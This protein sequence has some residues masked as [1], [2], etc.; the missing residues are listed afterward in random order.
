MPHWELSVQ[1]G[2]RID[3]GLIILP[4]VESRSKFKDNP[5]YDM[6]KLW[7]GNIPDLQA[8]VFRKKGDKAIHPWKIELAHYTFGV[9]MWTGFGKRKMAINF[10]RSLVE[11]FVKDYL[12]ENRVSF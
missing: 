8:N 10:A 3:N 11:S 2:V 12:E 5:K 7:T 9:R 6:T 4:I 1:Y